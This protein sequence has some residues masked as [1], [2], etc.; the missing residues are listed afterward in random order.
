MSTVALC[1]FLTHTHAPVKLCVAKY[2]LDITE[3]ECA[4]GFERLDFASIRHAERGTG[5][6]CVSTSSSN[7]YGQ[8]DNQGYYIQPEP[9]YSISRN[10]AR[11][12]VKAISH[13]L[14]HI[15]TRFHE[16]KA[17]SY[18]QNHI[19][20]FTKCG[21]GDNQGNSSGQHAGPEQGPHAAEVV[22]CDRCA[23]LSVRTG[24]G[25][26]RTAQ[27]REQSAGDVAY[28]C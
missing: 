12:R 17:I 3:L 4:F 23:R 6:E 9:T 20:D 8:G 28:G 18:N 21:Q 22:G 2:P 1:H 25:A 13:N 10:V 27:D 5:C 7:K 19:L 14:N 11:A 15:L 16:I 26:A 24:E